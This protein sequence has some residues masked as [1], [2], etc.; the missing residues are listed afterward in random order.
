MQI[1]SLKFMKDLGTRISAATGENHFFD[2]FFKVWASTNS[3][4]FFCQ[5][6][7]IPQ[8]IALLFNLLVEQ[9]WKICENIFLQIFALLWSNLVDWQGN[10]QKW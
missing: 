1:A 8:S 3:K 5:D 4:P 2:K 9:S 6:I 7:V 10:N